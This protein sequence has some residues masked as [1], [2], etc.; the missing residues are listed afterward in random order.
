[1]NGISNGPV[2]SFRD[3][4]IA[5]PL[6]YVAGIPAVQRRGRAFRDPSIRGPIE[7]TPNLANDGRTI[8]LFRDHLIAAPLKWR[9]L[10]NDRLAGVHSAIT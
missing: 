7:A 4:L 1:M 2:Q 8:R 3:H 9:A 5:A 10:L 6:K